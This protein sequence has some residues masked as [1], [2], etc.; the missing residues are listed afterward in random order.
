MAETSSEKLN[1]PP[2]TIRTMKKDLAGITRGEWDLALA[3]AEIQDLLQQFRER[4]KEANAQKL[5]GQQKP[6]P[7]EEE[8][9]KKEEKIPV[10]P[11]EQA[12]ETAEEPKKKEIS[13]SDKEKVVTKEIRKRARE[14]EEAVK[15]RMEKEGFKKALE[16]E[17][18]TEAETKIKTEKE[19]REKLERLQQALK[20]I[21]TEKI[22]L[23]E[24]Q[25]YYLKE[26][27]KIEKDLEPILE[28]ERKIE[29]N[30]K[31]IEG[32]EKTAITPRQ[33]KKAEQERQL[34]EQERETI[35]K[36]RWDY[37]QK[38]FQIEK[39][40]REVE[41]GFRQLAQKEAKIKQEID[42]ANQEIEKIEKA[43]EKT[44][45]EIKISQLAK[46]KTENDA[47]K[48]KILLQRREIEEK[49]AEVIVREQKLEKELNYVEEEE[50]LASETEKQRVEQERWKLEQTRSDIEKERW[51]AEEEKTKIRLEENRINV[52]YEKILE[53]ENQYR[54]RIQDINQILGIIVP[55]EILEPREEW[56]P[57]LE[58]QEEP[59]EKDKYR[60]EG[61]AEGKSAA[62]RLKG[63]RTPT[64]VKTDDEAKQM[65]AE[66][67]EP[68]GKKTVP[69]QLTEQEQ[70]K[71]ELAKIEAKQRREALLKKL[72]TVRERET[73]N[74][75]KQLLQR[76]RQGASAPET[77]A[78]QQ[79]PPPRIS[80]QR[81]PLMDLPSEKDIKKS[82]LRILLI[83]IAGVVIVGI[84]GFWYWY[85]RIRQKPAAN[86][87]IMPPIETAA[88]TATSTLSNG[89]TTE[90]LSPSTSLIP[91]NTTIPLQITELSILPSL[92]SQIL[93][94]TI[95]EQ[96]VFSRILME[97]IVENKFLSVSE[98]LNSLRF[99]PPAALYNQIEQDAT[100]FVFPTKG[101]S[102]FGFVAK[103]ATGIN[104]DA[105]M[106]A[107]KA[108]E[109][110]LITDSRQFGESLGKT[111]MVPIA[112]FQEENYKNNV[113]RYLTL[114]SAPDCFG[115]CYTAINSQ[116]Y[117][118]TCCKP[119]INLINN[120]EQ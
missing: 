116:L 94:N 88:P 26:Q 70:A 95:I 78:G 23:E 43:E 33:K 17:E 106:A 108:W 2:E 37:E 102:V 110:T 114:S 84:I 96:D 61:P 100:F 32:I 64:P 115:A 6:K 113:L 104:D 51:A 83:A 73:E 87:P 71:E 52:R 15:Q 62:E 13:A 46:E 1:I 118:A 3:E 99:N 22:P 69:G 4:Q 111:N 28:S 16:Q 101:Y 67:K 117:F 44:D 85:A 54:K 57:T 5:E 105:I 120:S 63:E 97:N 53:Q 90:P 34:A 27:A 91:I 47:I 18:K 8:P 74:K 9:K 89:T 35:E 11:V 55:K 40:L 93:N 109:P 24:S 49:V 60:E 112:N 76:I 29:E 21:P 72:R 38:K 66:T 98:A 36:Q 79:G 86:M 59:A 56:K 30:I 92:V 107:M 19:I 14:R 25:S 68:T 20:E 80:S 41:F 65:S 42:L 119:I 103:G 31:F 81:P 39:Q 50:R 75:E 77:A 10:K 45:I 12:E 48:A 82:K 58:L 7:Q